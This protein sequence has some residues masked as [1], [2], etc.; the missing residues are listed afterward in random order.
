MSAQTSAQ[1]LLWDL[2]IKRNLETS[3]GAIT[4]LDF[5]Q[6][7]AVHF[8]NEAGRDVV[9][10][11][12]WPGTYKELT[13]DIDVNNDVDADL[14]YELPDDYR[15]VGAGV[16]LRLASGITPRVIVSPTSWQLMSAYESEVAYSYVEDEVLKCT[17]HMDGANLVYFTWNWV[18]PVT[19]DK[20]RYIEH[21]D[22][23]FCFPAHLAERGAVW[24]WKRSRGQPY[25]G[26]FDETER[27][28]VVNARNI[29][30]AV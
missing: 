19:G 30:G 11:A 25:Q 1:R 9:Q 8:L 3:T 29:K 18:K 5:E 28:I 4:A 24:R 15:S 12:E 26:E 23:E 13:L 16:S 14:E 10:R 27:E 22:D 17:H 20:T 21:W 7:Q 6:Q 2:G